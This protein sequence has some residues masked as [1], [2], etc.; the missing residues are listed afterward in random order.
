MQAGCSLE[1]GF[2]MSVDIEWFLLA[3]AVTQSKV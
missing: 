2:V 1:I 3:N